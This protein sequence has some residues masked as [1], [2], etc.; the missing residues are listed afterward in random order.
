MKHLSVRIIL[1]FTFFSF[2]L[3]A[4]PT[5]LKAGDVAPDFSGINQEGKEIHLKEMLKSGAVVVFF[6]R[7]E[8]CPYCN[9]QLKTLQDSIHFITDKGAGVVAV[10]P[11]NADNRSKTIEKTKASFNIVSDDH[12]KIMNA[13]RVTFQLDEKTTQAYKGYGVI[14]PERNGTNG[15]DLPVPAV[16]IIN[17]E[18]TIIYRYFD[19]DYTKRASVKEIVSHL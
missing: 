8:W 10:T 11:E 4:Q 5:G 18:G 9:R 14:L 19:Q 13:Y 3:T 7:G 2:T 12:S 15:N 1:A 16:Y 17:K 6:Y